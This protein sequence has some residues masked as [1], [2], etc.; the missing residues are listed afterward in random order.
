MTQSWWQHRRQPNILTLHFADMK[1]DTAA[2]VRRIA[3][4]IGIELSKARL[5]NIVA[6]VSFE[7]MKRRGKIYAPRGGATWKGGADTFLNKGTNGR[8]RD[9]LSPRELALYD[10]AC[11]R[12]LSPDCRAWLET[13]GAV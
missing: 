11:E 1:A 3:V 6:A 9:V 5:K 8:W 7:A 12:S 10:A 13:G 2:A 4:F